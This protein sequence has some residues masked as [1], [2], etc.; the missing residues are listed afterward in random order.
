MTRV[1]CKIMNKKLLIAMSLLLVASLV[2]CSQP[3]VGGE[4]T[5]DTEAVTQTET[6][7][8][9]E[10]ETVA[11]TETETLVETELE[12][13][14][15]TEIESEVESDTE[16][17][18]VTEPVT[19]TVTE[20]VTETVTEIFNTA[21]KRAAEIKEGTYDFSLDE[22]DDEDEMEEI[23]EELEETEE[24]R[25]LD[26]KEAAATK[27]FDKIMTWVYA[28][29]LVAVVAFVIYKFIL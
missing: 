16:T 19:E 17:E 18:F 7:A 15:D 26:E 10:T 29:V 4:T 2:A 1:A 27:K 5:T 13:E 11:K 6:Q 23:P 14:Q 22:K 28:G 9:T 3:T 21:A 12:T 24:D 8:T 25:L 20:I